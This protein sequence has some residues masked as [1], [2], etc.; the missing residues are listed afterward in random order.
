MS[1][2][3]NVFFSVGLSI[4]LLSPTASSQEDDG[5]D[6]VGLQPVPLVN[7]EAPEV[8]IWFIADPEVPL[9]DASALESQIFEEFFKR[10]DIRVMTRETT[11]E[12]LQKA[13]DPEMQEC[14]GGDACLLKIGKTLEVTRVIGVLMEGSEPSGYRMLLKSF[15]LEPEQPTQL[16]SGG[17]GVLT[18]LLIGGVGGGVTAIFENSDQ[19]APVELAEATAGEK[20]VP[21]KPEK[22][23]EKTQPAVASAEKT[24]KASTAEGSPATATSVVARRIEPAPKTDGDV[25]TQAPSRPG[26]LRRHMWS[27][28]ALGTSI[29]SLA[30]GIGLGVEGQSIA[31]GQAVEYDSGQDS[32]GKTYTNA[33]NAMFG[34][35]GATAIASVILFFFIED[36]APEA[37]TVSLLP[38]SGGA[39]AVI[40]F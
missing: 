6:A 14:K 39:R 18:E 28:I 32:L 23:D 17:E 27:A 16:N 20:E 29:T 5:E 9:D 7:M 35:A 11:L 37:G 40:R 3:Y 12:K 2:R 33:A 19:Y 10:S 22:V 38:G 31:D 15:N 24:A 4:C 1:F 36:D 30:I 34:V 21:E 26:F 8:A 25:V 13:G